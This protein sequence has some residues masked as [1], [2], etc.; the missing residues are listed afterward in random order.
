MNASPFDPTAALNA[1]SAVAVAMGPLLTVVSG[2]MGTFLIIRAGF[3]MVNGREGRGVHD[4][5]PV[6]QVLTYALIGGCLVQFART[7]ANTRELLAGAGSEMRNVMAYV[8][9]QAAPSPLYT[10]ALQAAFLW[11][12]VLGIIAV[13]RGF[14]IWRGLASGNNA[15]AQNDPF[16]SGLWHILGGGICVNVGLN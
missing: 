13:L 4:D 15:S 5:V 16:F 12:G 6:G 14:Y 7:L 2:L 1:L 8:V 9:G 11:V 3:L 10:A